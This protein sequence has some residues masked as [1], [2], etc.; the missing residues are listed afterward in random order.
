MKY[1]Y[2]VRGR[3]LRFYYLQVNDCVRNY[4]YICMCRKH[5]IFSYFLAKGQIL[6]KSAAFL[7]PLNPYEKDTVILQK[8][9]KLILQNRNCRTRECFGILF[10]YNILESPSCLCTRDP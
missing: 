7:A 9:F 6:C 10:L 5:S 8:Y 1:S 4:M 3:H 2:S